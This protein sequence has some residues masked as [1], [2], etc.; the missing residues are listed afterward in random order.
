MPSLDYVDLAFKRSSS[1]REY[2]DNEHSTEWDVLIRARL[3]LLMGYA[4]SIVEIETGLTQKRVRRIRQTLRDEGLEHNSPRSIK[5]STS[6]TLIASK[7]QQRHASIV[8]ALYSALH[9]EHAKETDPLALGTAYGLFLGAITGNNDTQ[10]NDASGS[11]GQEDSSIMSING[12]W[13][14]AAELRAKEGCLIECTQCGTAF[15][16]AIHQHYQGDQPCPWCD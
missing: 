6:R 8:M 2:I 13:A 15:Y 12:A 4:T 14:L 5:R 3:L 9:P 10:R 11:D 1:T 7:Q 16:E